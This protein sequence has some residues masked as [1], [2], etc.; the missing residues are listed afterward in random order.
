MFSLEKA[1]TRQRGGMKKLALV[2]ALALGGCMAT[3]MPVGGPVAI[4][5]PARVGASVVTPLDLVEDSR[6]PENA[7]CVW[8]G[9]VVV[10]AAI[11]RGATRIERRLTLGE[12]AATPA[13]GVVLDSALP[14]KRAGVETD[15]RAYRFHFS[16]VAID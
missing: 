7:R 3:A 1:P 16:P 8:A 13:G 10:K 12:P 2:P 5:Q 6:C 14:E 4:G 9:R 15:P 11:E